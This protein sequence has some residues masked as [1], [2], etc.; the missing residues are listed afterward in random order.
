MLRYCSLVR[1]FRSVVFISVPCL[2]VPFLSF[3]VLFPFCSFFKKYLYNYIQFHFL[4]V[5]FQIITFI[6]TLNF[7][8]FL[9]LFFSNQSFPFLSFTFLFLAKLF[10]ASFQFLSKLIPVQ[11]YSI[12]IPF[13]FFTFLS[14]PCQ[15]VL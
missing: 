13:L 6:I 9:F 10:G 7:N 5:P 2:F 3:P 4:S 8:S 15:R 14:F 1:K 11:F 12:P